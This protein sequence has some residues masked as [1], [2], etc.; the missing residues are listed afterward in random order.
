MKMMKIN[1][2]SRINKYIAILLTVLLFLAAFPMPLMR[3]LADEP[4]D[5]G[6]I[7]NTAGTGQLIEIHISTAEDLR[8][9]AAKCSLDSWSVD[10]KVILDKNLELN[11][12]EFTAIPTFGGIFEGSGKT[13]NG[14][15]LTKDGSYQG[16][17]RYVQ[18]G[19][20]VRNLTVKGH[21][22]PSGTSS[23][24]GGIAGSNRGM[25][26]NCKF[27][28]IADGLSNI[29]GIAGANE[30]TGVI[31]NCISEG[32]VYAEH[33]AGGIAGMNLGTI[34]N[35][36]NS[37]S[38]NTR[39]EQMDIDIKD[40]SIDT[41]TTTEDAADIT[42]IGGIAGYSAGIIKG[43]KNYGNAGY[44]HK[45]YNIGGIVGRQSGYITECSNYGRIYGRKEIGG[46]AGQMEPYR[47]LTF[48]E[49]TLSRLRSKNS[50]LKNGIDKTINDARGYSSAVSD[51]LTQ[52]SEAAD[53]MSDSLNIIADNTENL[54]NA[55]TDQIN[56]LSS[57]MSKAADMLV[58]AGQYL[59]D[60]AHDMEEAFDKVKTA[61]SQ[62][63]SGSDDFQKAVEILGDA[64]ELISVNQEYIDKAAEAVNN[65]IDAFD[66]G[67][68]SKGK[69]YLKEA[70]EAAGDSMNGLGE[71]SD[72]AAEAEP[73]MKNLGDAMSQSLKTLEEGMDR[74]KDTG[75]E[76]GDS[77]KVLQ[78]VFRYISDN[79]DFKLAKIDSS[80]VKARQDL[81]SSIDTVSDLMQ[82]LNLIVN[83][84]NN[85]LADDLQAV[86]DIINDMI[87]IIIDA[88]ESAQESVDNG[89]DSENDISSE[90][91][92]GQA[93]GKV[94]SCAN[95]GEVNG[96]VNVGGIAGAL[97]VE[98]DL[99]PEDDID[100]EGDISVKFD[101]STKAV[102]RD[103]ENNGKIICKK[104][105][106]GGIAGNVD[107]GCIISCNAYGSVESTDGDYTGGIAGIC[108]TLIRDS[109]A[110]CDILGN[111]NVGG[112][113][114]SAADISGCHSLVRINRFN[115]K[116]G[117]IA[118]EITGEA[119]D[120]YFVSDKLAGIDGVSYM[121][122]A[123]P[124]EWEEFAGVEN[125][126]GRF[127]EFKLTFMANGKEIY[128]YEFEYGASFNEENIPE[129]PAIEGC[130]AHWEKY[131]Y[132]KLTFDDVIH[133][134]YTKYVSSIES[135]QMR[136][137]D[138][139]LL[140]VEGR[141]NSGEK[142]YVKAV[143]AEYNTEH[144]TEYNA[145]GKIPDECWEVTI[146]NDGGET[147]RIHFVPPDNI[148][149]ADISVLY[150]GQWNKVPCDNDGAY[151]VFEARGDQVT[152]CIQKRRYIY[153]YIAAAAGAAAVIAA[154]VI[155][156]RKR[157]K[158]ES[159]Q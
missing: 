120:N 11:N 33:Y 57:H 135:E 111:N 29:G 145:D 52:I 90:D 36:S 21:I 14:I 42:D 146:P 69:E 108:R 98:H 32:M 144:N 140:L 38:V 25:I 53:T 51:K 27:S 26:S 153:L 77:A 54:I 4:D 126:P 157:K 39:I 147:H 8:N 127:L 154:A 76:L 123:E 85:L 149:K 6:D 74:M 78:E 128:T 75:S 61:A 10:K 99:D 114:G 95:Y 64:I 81:V 65:A 91:I 130:Q 107:L 59:E 151:L 34:E 44:Q 40:I 80:Q 24:A 50:E 43:S 35:C 134:V 119:A 70:V 109:N 101:Y 79:V 92:Q 15:S 103:S 88:Q 115:E 156:A 47:N 16:L 121:G 60:A 133:A 118:G 129:I 125:L 46:I 137:E 58:P 63:N 143:N 20:I 94:D 72:K 148:K 86:S 82:E 104:D 117:A 62:M 113:A 3:P 155:I 48:S 93:D 152:F 131:D 22:T 23:Y 68:R 159:S 158:A 124:L 1:S 31:Y 45:G 73:Y 30:E 142:I 56:I 100:I 110:K 102:I 5:I 49:T 13:I 55:D 138:K 84:K 106:A 12:E 9:L 105:C 7:N 132:S 87:N 97:A 141:F 28:G 83:S 2:G 19:A 89:I 67:D 18:E 66:S 112:I 96:D 122:K 71:A 150:G 41:L 37:S 116:A 136:S 139:A 17:F